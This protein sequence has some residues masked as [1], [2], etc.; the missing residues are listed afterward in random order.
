MNLTALDLF[1]SVL[2]IYEGYVDCGPIDYSDLEIALTSNQHPVQVRFESPASF[3][4]IHFQLE[5]NFPAIVSISY[6]AQVS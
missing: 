5:H 4:S 1:F 2:I 6:A 3:I